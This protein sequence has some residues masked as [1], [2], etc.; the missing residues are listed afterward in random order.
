MTKPNLFFFRPP[1]YFNKVLS[2]SCYCK[3]ARGLNIQ[4]DLLKWA[5]Q[6]HLQ[7]LILKS[8]QTM[9]AELHQIKTLWR[10]NSSLK[11]VELS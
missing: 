7:S 9:V 5:C 8:K 11:R 2:A 6:M 1:K 3:C 10:T 4:A